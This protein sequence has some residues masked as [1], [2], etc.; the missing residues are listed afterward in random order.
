M[1]A[2]A[3]IASNLKCLCTCIIG[4]LSSHATDPHL[5]FELRMGREVSAANSPDEL[6]G[7][8]AQ[9]LDWVETLDLPAQQMGRLD[10]MLSAERLPSFSAI[11]SAGR[12]EISRVL[13]STRIDT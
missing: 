13:A 1:D 12:T 5:Y 10:T 3:D 9:L 11:R 8:A 2:G 6:I 7:L 4:F